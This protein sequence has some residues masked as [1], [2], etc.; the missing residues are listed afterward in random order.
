M[1]RRALIAAALLLAGLYAGDDVWVR[2][3][4][5]HKGT[6]DPLG[7]VTFYYATALK[8]GR[9]EVFYD[10]PGREVC[11]RALFPHLGYRP[12]WYAGRSHVRIASRG[13]PARAIAT[14]SAAARSGA[15]R[16]T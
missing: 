10:Q 8:S 15:G 1:L 14:G 7:E 2:Y 12:C 6:R 3:R 5:A 13:S 9:V 4:L 16:A 11:V